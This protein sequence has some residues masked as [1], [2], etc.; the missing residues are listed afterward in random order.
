MCS[1]IA[2]DLNKMIGTQ[3]TQENSYRYRSIIVSS[4][5][6]NKQVSNSN[7]DHEKGTVKFDT[8]VCMLFEYIAWTVETNI[9]INLTTYGERFSTDFE[10]PLL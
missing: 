5:S 7:E 9:I 10:I 8:Q 6:S 2:G 4:N 1:R 3:Y